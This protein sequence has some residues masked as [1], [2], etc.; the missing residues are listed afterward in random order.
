[1]DSLQDNKQPKIVM[2]A[3]RHFRI[4][5]PASRGFTLIEL[6]VVIAVIGILAALLLPALGRAKERVLVAKCLS[7]LR[8]IG[9]AIQMYRDDNDGRYPTVSGSDWISFRLG[10]DDGDAE[11]AS[12]FGLETATHR[13]LWQ[14]TTSRD[15]YRCPADRGMNIA[16]HM[17][18]FD[19][20]YAKIGTSYKYNEGP[21]CPTRERDAYNRGIQG[22]NENCIR[23]P[24][25]RILM[26][27]P[28]AGPF[29]WGQGWVYF[30]W[31]YARGP[32]TVYSLAQAKDRFISPI[33]FADGHAAVHDFTANI[34]ANPSY[35]CEPTADWYWY[36]P[37]SGTR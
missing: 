21:N 20:L 1:L 25:R 12:R 4:E 15:V 31:H 29:N 34:R 10:G 30:F 3:H 18:P 24:S 33:L 17:Q 26:N 13:A 5:R 35:P 11:A 23:D 2:N 16:P 7:N 6:L 27:E 36:E 37:A 19:N 32:N 9:L 28:P 22:Q 14:Y 8:E